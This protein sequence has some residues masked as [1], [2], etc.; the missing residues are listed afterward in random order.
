[1]I[2]IMLEH[3]FMIKQSICDTF[4]LAKRDF[5]GS[6][7]ILLNTL[8]TYLSKFLNWFSFVKPKV[9]SVH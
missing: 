5:S 7:Q 2:G 3:D 1:M 6:A 8:S 9:S 4:V